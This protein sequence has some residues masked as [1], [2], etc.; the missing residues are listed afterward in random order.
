M[1][2]LKNTRVPKA[3]RV[4]DILLAIGRFKFPESFFWGVMIGILLAYFFIQGAI[5]IATI[6]YVWTEFAPIDSLLATA[7]AI[8]L[9]HASVIT[10]LVLTAQFVSRIMDRRK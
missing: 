4:R 6:V 7:W 2:T 10:I 3:E 5:V 9:F 8:L 1:E